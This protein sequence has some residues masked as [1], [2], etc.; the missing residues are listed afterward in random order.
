MRFQVRPLAWSSPRHFLILTLCYD[1]VLFHMEHF[2]Q[3]VYDKQLSNISALLRKS[4]I[5]ENILVYRPK[6]STRPIFR[7][8]TSYRQ[9][10]CLLPHHETLY[11]GKFA[12]AADLLP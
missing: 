10:R 2:Y 1:P 4:V 3:M 5:Q 12:S 9:V 6:T 7:G 8:L 11:S